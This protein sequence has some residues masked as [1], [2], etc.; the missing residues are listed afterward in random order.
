VVIPAIDA[1]AEAEDVS[2]THVRWRHAKTPQG[3]GSPVIVGDYLF[4]ASP[5]GVLRC[6]KVADGEL[7][8]E[9]RVDGIPTYTSPVATKDGRIYFGSLDK[10]T[11][12]QAG[13]KL[14]VLAQNVLEVERHGE[15]GSSGPSPA[16]AEGR[17]FL[18]S[19]RA[20]YCIGKK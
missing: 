12:I 10:T 4:R 2:K 15:S 8:F 7:V 16:V 5:P 1:E 18:R 20:L 9:E 13:P 14:A 19:P 11:V 3:F 17:I 6:W